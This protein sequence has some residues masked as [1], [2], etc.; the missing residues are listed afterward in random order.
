MKN[1][2]G[3]NVIKLKGGHRKKS[4]IPSY[5]RGFETPYQLI[6]IICN[7]LRS[8]GDDWNTSFVHIQQRKKLILVVSFAM[9]AAYLRELVLKKEGNQN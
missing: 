4:K 5:L 2:N 1:T 6:N 8:L 3:N 7:I 9:F